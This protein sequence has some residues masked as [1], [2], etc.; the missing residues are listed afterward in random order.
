MNFEA[1]GRAVGG[2]AGC[3]VL[4]VCS[5]FEEESDV[6]SEE[7]VVKAETGRGCPSFLRVLPGRDDSSVAFER[8]P[9]SSVSSCA[10][11]PGDEN[12]SL[13]DDV[14]GGREGVSL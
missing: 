2:K 10:V 13:V 1:A 4:E 11:A 6:V 8:D 7:D 14:K 3:V 5:A 12:A 9:A